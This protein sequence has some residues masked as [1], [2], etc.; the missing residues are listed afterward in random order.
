[1][2]TF[3]LPFLSYPTSNMHAN[4]PSK[5]LFSARAHGRRSL[6][7]RLGVFMG[8]S[9]GTPH[10]HHHFRKPCITLSQEAHS[11]GSI[12]QAR[13]QCQSHN[14]VLETGTPRVSVVGHSIASLNLLVLQ[15]RRG[16]NLSQDAAFSM[17]TVLFSAVQSNCK[18]G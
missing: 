5:K 15:R 1:M 4:I 16:C 10:T 14:S 17:W 11:N 12:Q 18:P 2:G 7:P 6:A 9:C 13:H 3:Y 8:Q